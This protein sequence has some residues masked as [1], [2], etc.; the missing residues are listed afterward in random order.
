[1][2]K[3]KEPDDEEK[4]EYL[5][6]S[7]GATVSDADTHCPNCGKD[8]GE[9][10]VT[11]GSFRVPLSE[12][13]IKIRSR[14]KFCFWGSIVS[15]SLF[16]LLNFI[17]PPLAGSALA[18]II[19]FSLWTI[20]FTTSYLVFG[21]LYL[22]YLYQFAGLLRKNGFVWLLV[23]IFVPYFAIFTLIHFLGKTKNLSMKVKVN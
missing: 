8:F 14:F 11:K 12:K 10:V 22:V 19:L 20:L 7:C 16:L 17:F 1:M 4:Y 21:I 13:G 6:D 15:F 18:N 3:D 2:T 5:C 23:L 9:T